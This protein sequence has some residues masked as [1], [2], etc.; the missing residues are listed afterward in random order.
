M[1]KTCLNK[2][3]LRISLKVVP[4]C[5]TRFRRKLIVC[6]VINQLTYRIHGAGIYAN[7]W[8]YID[9]IHVTIFGST[10]DPSWVTGASSCTVYS[11]I[12]VQRTAGGPW[13]SPAR[14]RVATVQHFVPPVCCTPRVWN[15]NRG[16]IKTRDFIFFFWDEHH[17][18]RFWRR[19]DFRALT[20]GQV[21][22]ARFYHI[23]LHRQ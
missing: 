22:Q 8:G 18:R 1:L 17:S 2:T 16:W 23:V 15:G 20:H 9:G 14:D 19:W 11:D 13:L 21:V 12:K 4:G 6:L 7:N 3:I 5:P 10:M